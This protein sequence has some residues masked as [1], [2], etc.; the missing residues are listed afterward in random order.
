MSKDIDL[1]KPLSDEDRAWLKDHSQLDLIAEN[2]RKFK[3][4]E[5]SDPDAPQVSPADP[6]R[7]WEPGKEPEQR[8]VQRPF[9]PQV[10]GH[11]ASK[12]ED[13]DEVKEVDEGE[14]EIV[15]LEDLTVEELKDELRELGLSTSGSKKEL[16]ERLQ[17]AE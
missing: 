9:D 14:G 12:A 8:F 15:G 13:G 6:P 4:P 16:Q 2:D 10:S 7:F 1:D 11:F 3:E 5:E 17:K